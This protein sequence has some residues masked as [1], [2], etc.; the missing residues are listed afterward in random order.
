MLSVRDWFRSLSALRHYRTI[1]KS[2]LFNSRWYRKTQ[3]RGISRLADPLFHYL[4]HGAKKGL[5]PAPN[6]HT[7]HYVFVNHDVRDSKINPLFHYVEYGQAEYRLPLR[8]VLETRDYIIPESSELETFLS[9]DFLC[10][11]VTLVI[12]K[13]SCRGSS[14][15]PNTLISLANEFAKKHERFLRVILWRSEDSAAENSVDPWPGVSMVEVSR[16]N[17]APTFAISGDEYFIASSATTEM[18]LR[19]TA[20]ENQL[21]TIDSKKPVKVTKLKSSPSIIGLSELAANKSEKATLPRTGSVP[22]RTDKTKKTLLI[23]GDVVAQPERYVMALEE[24]NNA[25]L[26]NAEALQDWEMIVCG[27]GVAPLSIAGSMTVSHSDH[28]D[29]AKLTGVDLIVNSIED[30]EIDRQLLAGGL[31]VFRGAG[32]DLGRELA[33]TK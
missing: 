4:V 19:F 28:L 12:D 9:P 20:P 23:I 24:A 16:S 30:R 32:E 27:R 15:S 5:D 22:I 8:S 2:G 29:L 3:V 13:W 7:R 21:F 31:N 1:L 25:L 10:P 14:N 33:E 17:P 18:S 6:F 11:R 26:T